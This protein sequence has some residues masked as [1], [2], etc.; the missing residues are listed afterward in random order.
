MAAA[1]GTLAV[2]HGY[3]PHLPHT[4]ELLQDICAGAVDELRTPNRAKSALASVYVDPW[5]V[6]LRGEEPSPWADV[7]AIRP[8]PAGSDAVDSLP[9][10]I[11]AITD[12][13]TLYVTFGTVFGSSHALTMV[14]EAVRDLPCSVVATTG[15]TV[16]PNSLGPLRENVVVAPFLPQN[17]VL[18]RSTA[19]GSHA[20]SG[21]VLGALAARLPQVCLPL[22]ADQFINAEGLARRG[23]GIAI[24]PERRDIESIRDAVQRVLGEGSYRAQAAA[25]QDEIETMSPARD[26]LADLQDRAARRSPD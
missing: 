14:L 5:P 15:A 13:P 22:G 18:A 10:E 23:A 1:L 12:R 25:L 8:D 21:T 3:G 26:V 20:G 19:V 4:L 16:D 17:L 2:A 9:A 7:I 24:A 6:A 11:M